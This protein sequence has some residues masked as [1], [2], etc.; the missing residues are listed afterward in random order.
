[1]S[2][3]QDFVAGLARAGKTGGLFLVPDHQ[4]AAG[5]QNPDPGDLQDDVGGGRQDHCRR[6]LCRRLQALV[7]AQ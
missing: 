2:P 3:I 1:M 4:E 7:Q 5:G 6:G